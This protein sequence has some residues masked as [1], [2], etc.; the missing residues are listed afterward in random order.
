[1]SFRE[2]T[3]QC[4]VHCCPRQFP[5]ISA[6]ACRSKSVV[7][8]FEKALSTVS[9]Q[10]ILQNANC[11]FNVV[12]LGVVTQ[13]PETET[14]DFGG[15]FFFLFFFAE[16]EN[17]RKI[18]GVRLRSTNHSPPTSLGSNPS[19]SNEHCANLTLL[20]MCWYLPCWFAGSGYT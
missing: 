11:L 10:A 4:V 9:F 13:P 16:G 18:L 17:R 5:A 19:R 20:T 15:K 6:H 1:M 14:R 3:L 2:N 7:T 8:V 12:T